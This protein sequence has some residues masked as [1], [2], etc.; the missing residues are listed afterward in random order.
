MKKKKKKRKNEKKKE[1]KKPEQNKTKQEIKVMAIVKKRLLPHY[2]GCLLQ[3]TSDT[4]K[5]F[6]LF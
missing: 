4:V 2:Q 3:I 1:R 6:R 5:F